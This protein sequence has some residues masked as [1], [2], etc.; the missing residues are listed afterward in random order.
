MKKERK[1]QLKK[2]RKLS[3]YMCQELLYDYVTDSLDNDRKE[4]VKNFLDNNE[5]CHLEKENIEFALKYLNQLSKTEISKPVEAQ[6]TSKELSV[7]ELVNYLNWYRWN[8]MLRW[9]VQA[10][11]VSSIVAFIAV[12]IPWLNKK[13][14]QFTDANTVVLAKLS[15]PVGEIVKQG[16]ETNK[17]V[18]SMEK[19]KLAPEKV[20]KNIPDVQKAIVKSKSK[21][22]IET[23]KVK[24]ASPTVNNTK[25]ETVLSTTATT[26]SIS[27]EKN[28]N[29]VA[30]TGRLYRVYMVLPDL[31]TAEP[32]ITKKIRALNGNKAG[33]VELGLRKKEGL[34]YHFIMP[35]NNETL[36]Y[37]YLK[38]FGAVKVYEKEHSRVMAEG[39]KRF[40]L[41][42]QDLNKE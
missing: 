26:N 30:G 14:F 8:D 13:V 25:T 39:Q 36:L 9:G 28:K 31:E 11:A 24:Q 23:K 15:R 41:W 22:K 16:S 1:P 5:D 37:N 27:I 19:I 10:L 33:R 38:E 2:E 17:P 29:K 4:D 20:A 32:K 21:E 6:L 12:Q 7:H 40:I 42:I 18:S 34:Y 35:S 3:S